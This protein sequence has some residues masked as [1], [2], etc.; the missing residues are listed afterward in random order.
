MGKKKKHQAAAQTQSSVVLSNNQ[1]I[2]VIPQDSQLCPACQQS[3][4]LGRHWECPKCGLEIDYL[5]WAGITNPTAEQL[6]AMR[7]GKNSMRPNY[8]LTAV[9]Y[10]AVW[11]V[12]YFLVLH[13]HITGL[14][15]KC[16]G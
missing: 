5:L 12:L 9:L 7:S 10:L 14:M 11:V 3:I 16:N 2:A 4:P 15:N 8:A 6:E 13:D 1:P